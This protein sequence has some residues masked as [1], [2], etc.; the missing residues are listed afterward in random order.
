[1]KDIARAVPEEVAAQKAGALVSP[2]GPNA[3]V[4]PTWARS[5]VS[6]F[7]QRYSPP[8]PYLGQ[9]T[10]IEALVEGSEMSQLTECA[11]CQVLRCSSAHAILTASGVNPWTVWLRREGRNTRYNHQRVG[12]TVV[13]HFIKK[14]MW[15]LETAA[16][17]LLGDDVT[18]AERGYH[19]HDGHYVGPHSAASAT[20]TE[21]HPIQTTSMRRLHRR[22]AGNESH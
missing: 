1:M 15:F 18:D 6:K 21:Q 2:F 7:G 14:N 11:S 4:P 13:V 9:Q 17:F 3:P 12:G 10:S 5:T 20:L 16:A 19:W 8:L 22:P